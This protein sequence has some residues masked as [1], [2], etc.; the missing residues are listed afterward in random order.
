MFSNSFYGV[1][2]FFF[3]IILQQFDVNGSL[4]QKI[5]T[6]LAVSSYGEGE[7]ISLIQT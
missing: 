1:S 7:L 5:N 2:D 3:Q 6:R 4:L